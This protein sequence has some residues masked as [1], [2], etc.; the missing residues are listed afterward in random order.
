M[1]IDSPSISSHQPTG[2]YEQLY[3]PKSS[4]PDQAFRTAPAAPAPANGDIVWSPQAE[5]FVPRTVRPLGAVG[6]LDSLPFRW[7]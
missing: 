6:V 5:V 4:D 7:A 1:T 3:A 2:G